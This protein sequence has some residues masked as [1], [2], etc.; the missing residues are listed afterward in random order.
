[1]NLTLK[2]LLA[3]LVSV[4][5]FA[6]N[7]EDPK[8]SLSTSPQVTDRDAISTSKPYKLSFFSIGGSKLTEL[9]RGG[10]AGFYNYLG[11]S[12]KLDTSSQIAF[13]YVFFYDTAGF[14]RNFARN[15]DENIDHRTDVGDPYFQYTRYGLGKAGEWELTGKTSLYLPFSRASKAAK[16]IAYVRLEPNLTRPVGKFSSLK[17][18]AKFDY[19]FQSQRVFLD[20]EVPR[21]DDGKTPESAVRT[22]RNMKLEHYMEFDWSLHKAFSIKPKAG[23]KESWDYGSGAEGKAS[24]HNC[25]AVTSLGVEVKPSKSFA[26]YLAIEN[27]AKVAELG[28]N[29]VRLGHPLDNSWVLITMA[30]F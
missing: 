22:T 28:G 19:F 23:F 25:A 26:M 2:T 4:Q 18:I 13:R 16:T 3:L 5:V 29:K 7:P 14:K 12:Y 8:T 17:Y 21:D 24:K 6:Q 15:I 20:E 1:M 10:S 27:E 9:E 30:S 11:I